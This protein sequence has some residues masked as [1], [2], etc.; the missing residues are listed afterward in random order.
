MLWDVRAQLEILSSTHLEEILVVLPAFVNDGGVKV[1]KL[2]WR[3][4]V[5]S[6][7]LLWIENDAI[8]V[9]NAPSREFHSLHVDMAVVYASLRLG[10]VE[11]LLG[12]LLELE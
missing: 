5:S 11:I 6:Q 2:L 1:L 8:E 12:Q 9:D 3:E 4:L 7:Q 10:V